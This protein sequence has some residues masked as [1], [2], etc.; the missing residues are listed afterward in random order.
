MS[1]GRL[2]FAGAVLLGLAWFALRAPLPVADPRFL[3][4]DFFALG[5]L[6]SVS[7]YLPEGMSRE[8]GKEIV[9]GL[10]HDFDE[11]EVRWRA[12]GKG[13]L[14]SMNRD[15]DAGRSIAIPAVMQPLFRRAE[16]ARTASG[17]RFD[18]RVGALTRL[19]GFDD[20]AHL[21]S[22]P[23]EAAQVE[24]LR[25]ALGQAPALSGEVYRA[26]GV[27]WDFG[28]IAKGA[29]VDQAVRRLREAGIAGA[30]VNAGGNL[31]STGRRGDA[32]WRIG[33]RD[34]RGT[35]P[36]TVTAWLLEDRDEAIMTSGDYERFFEYQGRRYCH[37]LDPA[38][39]APAQGLAAVTV[40]HG[41]AAWADAAS[42]ALFVA[43]PGH[44]RETAQAMGIEQAL[45]ITA[46]GELRVTAPLHARLK[47]PSRVHPQIVP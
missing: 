30:I 21:R 19:W 41:D 38:T 27:Q 8:R 40:V 9:A 28:G 37:I 10:R 34:P 4:E 45:V 35:T 24:R 26:D 13:E 32:P 18:A 17:G 42:T 6:V 1:T 25:A 14:A 33:L 16:E 5:T 44:W 39:G 3:K 36:D 2:A 11:Y 29:A 22:R 23:P 47:Y 7:A 20:E 12:W 43:G 31:R 15:L 46:A